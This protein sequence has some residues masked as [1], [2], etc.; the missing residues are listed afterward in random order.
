MHV[1]VCVCVCVCTCVHVC[2][3]VCV[4]VYKNYLKMVKGLY[5]QHR[6]CKK[7]SSKKDPPKT[8]GIRVSC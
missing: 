6:M 1:C 5:N 7:A 8:L 3:I 2:A 4:R